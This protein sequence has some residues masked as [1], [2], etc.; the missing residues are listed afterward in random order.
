MRSARNLGAGLVA[1]T[2]VTVSA[3]GAAAQS[4]A[5]GD[6]L[7]GSAW[8]LSEVG[9]APVPSGTD[10][11]LVFGDDHAGGFAGCNQ[12]VASYETDGVSTLTFGEVATT[13][14]ACDDATNE[15]EQTYLTSLGSVASYVPQDAGLTLVDAD[16]TNVLVYSAGAPASVE[17]PWIVTGFNNGQ[18]AVVSPATEETTPS[19][20]FQPDGT[21][22]GFSGCNTFGGGYSVDDTAI[23]IGPL[24]STMMSCGEET[25]TAAAQ[26]LTALEAATTWAVSGSTLEL[27][28]DG[29]ALQVSATSAIGN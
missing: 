8:L 22:E 27:R 29:G 26:F 15:F 2:L 13:M 25:D 11:T 1:L 20:S 14:I 23:A 18:E 9:G 28:D 7:A 4:P 19:I 10:A 5:T 21:V 24:F 16:G 3:A 6:G 17:G 12:F